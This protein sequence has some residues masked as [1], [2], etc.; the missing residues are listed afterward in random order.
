[1]IDV[2]TVLKFRKY[3]IFRVTNKVQLMR[4][5]R[6]RPSALPQ[7]P[8][9]LTDIATIATANQATLDKAVTAVIQGFVEEDAA[10]VQEIMQASNPLDR[11][12]RIVGQVA[13]A[14]PSGTGTDALVES[15][16]ALREALR[17][18]MRS[19]PPEALASVWGQFK[20]VPL[21]KWTA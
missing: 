1:L 5:T 7:T 18:E 8:D 13:K 9:A 10:I 12:A 15:L 21:G 19:L 17:P 16:D 20:S 4:Q 2:L 6:T 11:L 14:T 3:P